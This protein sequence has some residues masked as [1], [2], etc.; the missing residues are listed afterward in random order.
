MLTVIPEMIAARWNNVMSQL[1]QLQPLGEDDRGMS[2]R[3]RM[4]CCNGFP[5]LNRASGTTLISCVMQCLITL[6]TAIVP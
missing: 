6:I 3:P 5:T 1:S 2:T 4:I